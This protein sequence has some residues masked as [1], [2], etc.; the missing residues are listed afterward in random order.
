MTI[1]GA[2]SR[3]GTVLASL[4]HTIALRRATLRAGSPV[5]GEERSAKEV[6][7]VLTALGALR[8]EAALS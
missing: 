1:E 6:V 3:Y 7:H 5:D 2:T 4:E 8:A